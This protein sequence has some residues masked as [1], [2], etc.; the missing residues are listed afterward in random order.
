MSNEQLRIMCP[1]LS[2][3]KIL[4]APVS[5]RGKTIRC[6]AC[7]STIRVPDGSKTA[8]RKSA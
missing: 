7:G 4:L 8:P 3:R 2:C 6:R 1:K 5:A